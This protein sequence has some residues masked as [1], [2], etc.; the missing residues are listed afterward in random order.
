MA[1]VPCWDPPGPGK[2]NLSVPRA[3]QEPSPNTNLDNSLGNQNPKTAETKTSDHSSTGVKTSV[4]SLAG[5]KTSDHSLTGNKISVHSPGV[6]SRFS[7]QYQEFDNKSLA[8]AHCSCHSFGFLSQEQ[9]PPMENPQ[10]GV[11][12]TPA[13]PQGVLTLRQLLKAPE[14]PAPMMKNLSDNSKSISAAAPTMKNPPDDSESILGA[15]T[16]QALIL[17]KEPLKAPEEPAPVMKNLPD[18]SESILA[19]ALVPPKAHPPKTF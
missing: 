14:E 15:A 4:H 2:P 16:S 18:D 7:P 3:L 6:K 19:V 1:I 9:M 11:L 13:Q 12:A 10:F 8:C 5:M 17:P